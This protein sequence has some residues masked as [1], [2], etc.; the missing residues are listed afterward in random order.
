MYKTLLYFSFIVS[1]LNIS[2]YAFAQS[3]QKVKWQFT[4]V[5]KGNKLYE[6]HLAANIEK[7]W[8]LYSQQQ[9]ADA[10]AL[11]TTIKFSKNPM[12]DIK[13]KAR[14]EGKLYDEVEA[15]TRT[16]SR[17]YANKVV[18]VQQVSLKKNVKTSLNG[19]V[20]FMVCD[21]RQCLPPGTV[22]FSVKLQ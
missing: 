15:A 21:D 11:P 14:E 3:D 19:E 10:I 16:R 1:F 5:K 8:H 17:Y 6:I 9:S 4:A 12:I 20:E 7:G 18:F 13:G 2:Y 22:K